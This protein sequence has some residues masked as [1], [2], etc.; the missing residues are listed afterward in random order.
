MK[1]TPVKFEPRSYQ[2]PAI[3]F[4]LDVPRAG[5][6]LD[7]GMGK[8]VCATSVIR[9]TLLSQEINHWLIVAPLRVC[10]T[11]WRSEFQKWDEL[12]DLSVQ[13]LDG[14]PAGQRLKALAQG[15]ADVTIINIDLLVWL[16]NE[17][18]ISEWPWDGVILDESSKYKSASTA[19][20]KK[21]RKVLP[22]IDRLIELTGSPAAQ[23]L[24]GLWSQMFLL[25]FGEAL[26]R[27]N[28]AYKFTFFKS[29]YM[30]Y[31]F[32]PLPG[33]SEA[34]EDAIRHQ[35]LTMRAVDHLDFPDTLYNVI[36]VPLGEKAAAQYLEM[37]R[38]SVLELGDEII[39]AVNAGVLTGKLSQV[40]NGAVYSAEDENKT[41]TWNELHTF[42]LDALAEFIG[43]KQGSPFLLA[44]HFISDR[45]RLEAR[46]PETTMEF[47]NG[48]QQQLRRWIAGEIPVLAAQPQSAGHGVDNLQHATCTVVWLGP[49]WSRELYDQFNGRVTGARQVGTKFRGTNA[50]IHHIIASGTIDETAM[51]VLKERGATQNDF[52]NAL[53]Q[54]IGQ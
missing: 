36:E 35:C 29:D 17:V 41:K 52:L 21:L 1:M 2:T 9:T 27:T 19:R 48:S 10:Q 38:H 50:V 54:R 20:F 22:K 31:K 8:S 47:F 51:A 5:L 45:A 40:A 33:A 15:R 39:T 6:F 37:E 7:V 4:L 49:P 34:I 42:K 44:Y 43:E 12:K 28:S 11:T 25:D 30:G 3:Q 14:L 53:K 16:I 18:G 24:L 23:G 13:F 32:E 46:F 26:G